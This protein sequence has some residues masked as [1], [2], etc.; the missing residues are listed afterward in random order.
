[1]A[2]ISEEKKIRFV[3]YL[4]F[5]LVTFLFVWYL[6]W[7]TGNKDESK[8]KMYFIPKTIDQGNDFW[9]SLID[10]AYLGAKEYGVDL[11]VDGGRSEQDV[12]GQIKRIEKAIE[13]KPDAILISPCSY[14]GMNDILEK[15][16]DNN[17]KLI[18]IDSVI[19]EKIADGIVATDNYIAGK[20]LGESALSSIGEDDEVA[21]MAHVK[22]ASTAIE[23]QEGILD[24]IGGKKDKVI[25]TKYC[26]SSYDIAY[27]LTKEIIDENPNVSVIFGT[28]EYASVGAARAVKELDKKSEIK[29]FG[30]D[31][32]IEEIKLLEEGIFSAII[33]QK[34]FN[35]GYLGVEKAVSIIE[36]EDTELY[37]DSGCKLIDINN[38][39]EEDNQK[40]LYPF[41]GQK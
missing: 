30:F 25:A 39:Y 17:I 29:V 24:G 23:R 13:A 5:I 12:N 16:V 37:I 34:P 11:T 14:S 41:T 26:G 8:Y 31:N 19:D 21:I 7:G 33:I 9:T 10:G 40:L 27:E 35:M 22:G 6:V 36:N 2:K 3:A 18:L 20:Q 15:V 4:I 28:N 1:M 38:M 32:S